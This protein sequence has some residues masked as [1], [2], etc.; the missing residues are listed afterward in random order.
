MNK[1]LK[2]LILG[3]VLATSL[4]APISPV[5]DSGFRFQQNRVEAALTTN[6]LSY[7][8]FDDA[9]DATG[10][11]H[12]GTVRVGGIT[13]SSSNAIIPNALQKDNTG[14]LEITTPGDFDGLSEMT[15]SG[16][17]TAS[18]Y[19][20][21]GINQTIFI[22]QKSD[23]SAFTQFYVSEAGK[24]VFYPGTAT[25]NPAVS[26]TTLSNGTRYFVVARYNGSAA[27]VF[28]TAV[29][30]GTVG[31]TGS[32][33]TT[34]DYVNVGGVRHPD[35]TTYQTFRG[36]IDEMGF[37]TRALTD[38]EILQLYSGGNGC[39]YNLSTCAIPATPSNSRDT[40]PLIFGTF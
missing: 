11:G 18:D 36:T 34:A 7:W 20:I 19:A 35:T 5:I 40:S 24:L 22:A 17:I 38:T 8:P 29:N 26:A 30:D 10:N 2:N 21:S 12:T 25:N 14:R 23:L 32:T 9:S 16:W 1:K 37:W 15:I 13:Y 6:L 27:D 3:L 4:I 39:T 28:I 31:D 33:F